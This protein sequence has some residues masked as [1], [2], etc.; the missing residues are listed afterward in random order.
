MRLN[1]L[2]DKRGQAVKDA[3][4]IIDAAEADG[5][6]A[7]TDEESSKFDNLWAEQERLGAE[8]R[9]LEQLAEAE[10]QAAEDELR[11]AEAQAAADAGRTVDPNADPDAAARAVT[12]RAGNG[13]ETTEQHQVAA[14]R[15]WL[16]GGAHG[17]SEAE[18]RALQADVDTGGGYLT[19]PAFFVERLIKFLD[20]EVFIRTLAQTDFIP[21]SESGIYPSLD[22]DPD[23][24]DWTAE[25]GTGNED[26]NMAFGSRELKPHPL[27]KRIKVSNKLMRMSPSVENLVLDRL[28]YKFAV[29]QE[30]A[31][32]TGSG[33]NQP[34]GVFTASALGISTG[35]DVSADNTVTAPTFDGLK[36]LQFTLKG[37]Y[38][39]AA[40]WIMHRD[41]VKV[42]AKI[43]DGNG[44]YIWSES[45][46]DGQPDRLLGFPVRMSEFSPNTL[47]TGL[48]FALLG[49]FSKYQILDA[50]NM[51]LQRLVEL[52]A[53]TNQTG[54]IGR[55]ETDGM[56]VLEEAFVRGQLA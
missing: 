18:R 36:N 33:A 1:E 37:G 10:R 8:I 6:R 26:N 9:R 17:M 22:A 27:A 19:A 48:Y 52:Y 40:N 23:D 15:S 49:D 30:K 7:L 42:I 14:L 51:Q 16:V 44:Q 47:T 28:G 25:L 29:T 21:Q 43:K 35:R 34:L 55:M 5:Q 12:D 56:P 50:L 54:F 46:Q 20:D 31:F 13:R 41:V 38:W 2:R 39:A 4:A 45:V 3:R 53:E 24:A 11:R 32:L